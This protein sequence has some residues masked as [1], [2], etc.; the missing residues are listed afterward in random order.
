MV[1][2]LNVYTISAFAALGGA[3]FGF[4]ISSMSGVLGTDQYKFYY[5]NPLGTRQGGI[6]S[7]MAAGSLVGALSSSILGDWL[8]RKVAIQLGA[9]LWCIGAILQAASNGVAM[10]VAGRVVA[11]LCVGLTSSLVPI[12]QSEIA[13]RKIRGRI[14][15]LQQ[16]AI[17]W[18]IMIQYFVQYGCSF[19]PSQAAF[20]LPWAIQAAPAVVLFV[21]LFWFP[22]SPRW[23]ASKDRWDE[24]LRVLADLRTAT[25][26]I[27]DPLVLAEYKEIED[28]IRFEREDEANSYRELFGPKMRGRVFL[29]MAVQG[30]SQLVGI[31]VLMYYVVYVLDSAGISN[32]LLASSVQY[33]INMV[34]TIPSILWT[35]RWG[36][37]PA[38]LLGA[39]SIGFWLFLIGG[40]LARYGEP[41]PVPDQSYTWVVIGHPVATRCIQACS[42]LTVASFAMSW[43]PV[44]WMYPPEIMPLRIRA[45]AVALATATNWAA[46]FALGL[47]VPPVL[48][49]IGWR[50]FFIFAA[51]NMAAFVH[52]W[53]AAPETKL[54]TLEEMDEIFQ[55]GGPLWRT[56]TG[57]KKTDRLDRLARDIELGHL[58]IHRSV[59]VELYD[60]RTGSIASTV[61]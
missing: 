60:L 8:S 1:R 18:G 13:P 52:V 40:L 30:W 2:L 7:A 58:K 50:M 32:T 42:Y 39:L 26:D 12:Y 25:G 37:R 22:K 56:F 6:T 33:I 21:G 27:N 15:S 46:N 41:N 28:Q 19:L 48:R 44:S 54:R 57:I 17:T 61:R 59:Q 5:G 29:A 4:D 10:L 53:L 45:K 36:R 23:L 43:G 16:F 31:N 55:H 9:I 20:R 34:M 49:R 3:L 24:A 35:D 47:A 11:G 38:L 51:F 14:V